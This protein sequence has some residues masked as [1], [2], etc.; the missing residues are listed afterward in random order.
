MKTTVGTHI[1]NRVMKKVVPLGRHLR[2]TML[3]IWNEKQICHTLRECFQ[4][5]GDQVLGL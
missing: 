3:L 2:R 5:E 1:L 4:V